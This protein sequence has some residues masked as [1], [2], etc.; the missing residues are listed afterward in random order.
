MAPGIDNGVS[1][2]KAKTAS[3]VQNKEEEKF[4][5]GCTQDKLFRTD[6]NGL[7]L[8]KLY[9]IIIFLQKIK[10]TRSVNSRNNSTWQV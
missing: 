4:L 5:P 2:V 1:R 9:L 10:H 6:L 3:S 8:L 7:N